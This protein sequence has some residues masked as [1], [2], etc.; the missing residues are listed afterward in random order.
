MR[1]PSV[2]GEVAVCFFMI[3]KLRY[4]WTTAYCG[5][6]LGLDELLA[7]VGFNQRVGGGLRQR[8]TGSV[9]CPAVLTHC[10]WWRVTPSIGA[11][12]QSCPLRLSLFAK[13]KFI[14]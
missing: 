11:A 8:A 14:A 1:F 12:A 9:F 3:V 5:S 4:R 7:S 10:G 2:R 13:G 6:A